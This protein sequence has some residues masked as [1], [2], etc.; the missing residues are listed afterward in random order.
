M[1]R[2]RSMFVVSV[3]VEIRAMV[4]VLEEKALALLVDHPLR[5]GRQKSS[6]SSSAYMVTTS[7][8]TTSTCTPMLNYINYHRRLA[9]ISLQSV[10]LWYRTIAG[11]FL[12]LLIGLCRTYRFLFI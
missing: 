11:L 7:D 10:K 6:S 4:S 12:W 2:V 1:Y 9:H 5:I 3:T 8:T